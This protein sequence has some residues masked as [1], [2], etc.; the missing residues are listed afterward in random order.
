MKKDKIDVKINSDQEYAII[1]EGG[2]GT[3]TF[4]NH[5]SICLKP[6]N[7]EDDFYCKA[8]LYGGVTSWF[9]KHCYKNEKITQEEK[10]KEEYAYYAKQLWEKDQV[11]RQI[12]LVLLSGSSYAEI[13]GFYNTFKEAKESIVN[14]VN[15][16]R[17]Q[18]WTFH[19][20]SIHSVSY[21]IPF[22]FRMI[23]SESDLEDFRKERMEEDS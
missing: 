23:E 20:Y 2:S 7:Y 13:E 10:D 19:S 6:I 17:E 11:G 12:F 16:R 5:C 8:K 18:G 21:P 3:I 1:F 14:L 15:E 9:H 4:P 22:W